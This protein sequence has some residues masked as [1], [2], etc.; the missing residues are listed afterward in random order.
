[1]NEQ[2]EKEITISD[3]PVEWQIIVRATQSLI[4]KAKDGADIDILRSDYSFVFNTKRSMLQVVYNKNRSTLEILWM[5]YRVNGEREPMF[6]KTYEIR[7][8]KEEEALEL[9]SAWYETILT[10]IKHKSNTSA[11]F[12]D[13]FNLYNIFKEKEL[14]KQ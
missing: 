1:M 8:E 11:T 6:I 12:Q 4:S 5:K 14:T 9:I 2:K 7:I 10:H 3:F 13:F